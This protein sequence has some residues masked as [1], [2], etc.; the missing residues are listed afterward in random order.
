MRDRI[1]IVRAEFLHNRQVREKL[2][3]RGIR[4]VDFY[5]ADLLDKEMEAEKQRLAAYLRRFA[6]W[7]KKN[8]K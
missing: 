2:A 8:Q 4:F 7:R 3:R 6:A 1:A 5:A